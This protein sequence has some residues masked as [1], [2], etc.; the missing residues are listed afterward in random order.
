MELGLILT[1]LRHVV[2]SCE[3]TEWNVCMQVVSGRRFVQ[4]KSKC[5][6]QKYRIEQLGSCDV[7]VAVHACLLLSLWLV[8]A[9][10]Q[11]LRSSPTR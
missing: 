5:H 7:N 9:L 1:F 10:E 11:T 3:V 4:Y 6:E 2:H 8:L